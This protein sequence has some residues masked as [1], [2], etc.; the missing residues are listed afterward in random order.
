MVNQTL[1]RR[2]GPGAGAR[3]P[4]ARC[5]EEERMPP[6]RMG[7]EDPRLPAVPLVSQGFG[8]IDYNNLAAVGRWVAAA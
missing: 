7:S 2:P 6:G 4:G 8:N 3:Y 1:R 5:D